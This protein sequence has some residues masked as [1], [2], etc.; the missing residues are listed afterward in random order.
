MPKKLERCVKKVRKTGKS[1]CLEKSG[2]GTIEKVNVPAT[3]EI[4][5]AYDEFEPGA[6]NEFLWPIGSL[7]SSAIT[8]VSIMAADTATDTVTWYDMHLVP[9]PTASPTI[10]FKPTDAPLPFDD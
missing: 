7:D 8:L 10:T 9:F 6:V 3:V 4:E 1:T 5:A 2:V